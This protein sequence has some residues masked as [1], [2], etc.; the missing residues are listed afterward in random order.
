MC[1]IGGII[2]INNSKIDPEIANNIKTSL[3]HRGP[4]NS[5]I[6]HIS[7]SVSLIHT[8]LAIIDI[9]KRSNQPFHSEDM[10]YW[11]VFNGEIYNYK[12]IRTELEVQGFK[13]STSGDT[14]VLLKGFIHHKE[15]ILNKL[16]GQFAFAIYDTISKETFIARDRVGIKPLYYSKY[17]EW[18]IFGSEMKTIDSTKLVPFSPDTESYL[19]YMRHLC[20]PGSNTGNKNISKVK[21][22]EYILFSADGKSNSVKYWDPFSIKIN[23]EITYIEAKERVEELLIE[24]VEYRK[25]SDVEVG[26]FLSGGLDSS[27]IGKLMKDSSSSKLHGFNID[28]EEHFE[29]YSGEVTEAEYASSNIDIELIKE[30]I[31]YGDFKKLL[32]NYSGY[33]DDLNGDEVGIPLY[34]L[35]KSA[36]S[37]GV[38]VVQVGEGADEL[39]YGYE[40]WLKFIRLNKLVK[41]IR[42]TNSKVSRFSS[43]RLN[44]LS[45]IIY[46]RTS[47]AGG[48]L[49][50]NL[51]EINKL[52]EGGVP[53]NSESLNYVDRKWD[54]YFSRDDAELSKWMTLID[55][56]IRLPELL[57]MRMDKLVMQSGIETRVPFLDHEFVEF[58]LTIPEKILLNKNNTKPLLKDIARKHIP[59]QI[60]DREK[61]GFR[62]PIGEW[63]KKDIDLFYDLVKTFNAETNLFNSQ[64]LNKVLNGND[65]QKKWYLINLSK[66]HT[67]RNSN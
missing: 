47:F 5:S 51:T 52:V 66:W 40:H 55:L 24:S 61:Q 53:N 67:S 59:N 34:F 1:G 3:E 27:F 31:K 37:K 39:F 65:F 15:K 13:F 8:R 58:V 35:G 62:A 7:E 54:E 16:R 12:E 41:P 10:R 26:L 43:H 29:G 50:F 57:L 17:K 4:D 44:L 6:K 2:N 49:G 25:I 63:I 33:Q 60:I 20:V 22:G 56:D 11:I 18:L 30:K 45:N 21:P 64:Q 19:S 9:D 36:R 28:Y 46:G 14:E 23:S 42:N 48:A 38:T 32:N